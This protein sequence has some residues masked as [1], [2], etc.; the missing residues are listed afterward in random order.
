MTCPVFRFSGFSASKSPNLPYPRRTM[1]IFYVLIARGTTVLAEFTNSTGNFPTI[2]RVI[3]G[4]ISTADGKISY[5]YDQ[6]VFHCLTE[7]EIT[8]LCMCDNSHKQRIP[9]E[10][11]DDLKQRFIS[12]YGSVI[13]TA[14][15]Y[16]MSEEFGR[17]MQSRMDYYNDASAD[18]LS[19]VTSKIDEVKNVMIQNID[20]VL[21]RGE[22]L[23]LLVEKTDRLQ[24]EAFKF[25]KS[26]RSLVWSIYC[27]RIKLYILVLFILCLLIW[28]ITSLICG[29][30]YDKCK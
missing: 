29:F 4:K 9:F 18:S 27:Q 10:F 22:K 11:L 6:H 3:L 14:I 25:E 19:K 26:S 1:T 7:N 16:A 17:I 20:M 24:S 12:R 21:E 30:D 5:E 23:E 28:L 2:T 8:Y 15:A 13:K